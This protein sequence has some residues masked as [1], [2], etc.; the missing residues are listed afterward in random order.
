MVAAASWVL[1]LTLPW[2][3]LPS[4]VATGPCLNQPRS[5][6]APCSDMEHRSIAC[7]GTGEA[8]GP[9]QKP[10]ARRKSHGYCTLV[11]RQ[12]PTHNP[13]ASRPAMRRFRAWK[14]TPL[15]WC[16]VCLLWADQAGTWQGVAVPGTVLTLRCSLVRV[17]AGAAAGVP[18]RTPRCTR[19]PI[20]H[21]DS[22]TSR[23]PMPRAWARA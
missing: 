20:A 8:Q 14:H 22:K 1:A 10:T 21:P 16:C 13:E 19:Q 4:T 17:D 6:R 23:G 2:L 12:Q 9:E 5:Y 11:A 15:F 3:L 7:R 18:S